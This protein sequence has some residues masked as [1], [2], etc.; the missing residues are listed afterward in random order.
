MFSIVS[1]LLIIIFSPTSTCAF[2]TF[3]SKLKSKKKK[4]NLG[5]YKKGHNSKLKCY[6]QSQATSSC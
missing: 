3:K 1:N 6:N 2:K 4:Y 5:S